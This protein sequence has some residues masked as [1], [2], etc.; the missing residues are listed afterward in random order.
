MSE[1]V[2]IEEIEGIVGRP[3]HPELHLGRAVSAEQRIYILHSQACRGTGI[4]L[5]DCDYSRALDRGTV[6]DWPEDEP[7]ALAIV[8]GYL[9]TRRRKP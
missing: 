3:R 4:D 9:A 6:G 5:R 2:P 7:M 1:L 8:G